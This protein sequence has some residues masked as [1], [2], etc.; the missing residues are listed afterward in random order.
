MIILCC[1]KQVINRNIILFLCSYVVTEI[2][3]VYVIDFWLRVSLYNQI[4]F[5][6]N[7]DTDWISK[8]SHSSDIKNSSMKVISVA[9]IFIRVKDWNIFS[10]LFKMMSTVNDLK[11]KESLSMLIKQDMSVSSSVMTLIKTDHFLNL[12]QFHASEWLQDIDKFY[13]QSF[14]IWSKVLFASV[15]SY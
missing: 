9:L 10:R 1:S 3:K 11:L 7:N 12:Q 13:V 14:C 8:H 15:L 2:Y 4:D 6:F 5:D